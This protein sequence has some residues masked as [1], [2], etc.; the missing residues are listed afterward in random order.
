M[1]KQK[2]YVITFSL[3]VSGLTNAFSQTATLSAGGDA[4]G[5]G[6]TVAFSVG[7]VMYTHLS[8][9]TGNI[10]YGVQ[11][12]Y[13]VIMVGTH[14][15]LT[16]FSATIYPNPVSSSVLL[17]LHAHNVII[18]SE[19]FSLSLY[20]TDGKLLLQ[21][22]IVSPVTTVP[23]ENLA[24]AIYILRITRNNDEIKDFKIFKTN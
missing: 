16:G 3:I 11:Q 8:G 4:T 18:E 13:S 21:Q 23:L 1:N 14:E 10:N 15:P 7:Q 19:E 24:S 5:T 6:G 9:E 17:S 2:I 12:P 20:D 22:K